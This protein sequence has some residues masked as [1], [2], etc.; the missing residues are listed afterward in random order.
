MIERIK[1]QSPKKLLIM[2]VN[3]VRMTMLNVLHMGKVTAS[4]IQNINPST[5]IAVGGGKT[6]PQTQCIY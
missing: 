5:E 1:K 2:I 3:L 4:L 6:D